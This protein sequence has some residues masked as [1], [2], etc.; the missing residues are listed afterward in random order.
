MAPIVP[1]APLPISEVTVIAKS[2]ALSTVLSAKIAPVVAV[3]P[4][5]EASTSKVASNSALFAVAL[6]PIWPNE[7]FAPFALIVIDVKPSASAIVPTVAVEPVA[8]V[9]TVRLLNALVPV[10]LPV[11]MVIYHSI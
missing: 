2:L 8:C 1:V 11:A 6:V 10:M 7:A 4:V 5:P 9:V 3:T